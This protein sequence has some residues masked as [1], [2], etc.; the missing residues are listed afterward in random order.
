MRFSYFAIFILLCFTILISQAGRRIISHYKHT[1]NDEY[2][3]ESVIG[4][5]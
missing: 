2:G 3:E 5:A 4:E 1:R